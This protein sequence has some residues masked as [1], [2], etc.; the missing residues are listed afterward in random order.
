MNGKPEV[1]R[2][3]RISHPARSRCLPGCHIV[4]LPE[5]SMGA[6]ARF[7]SVA[8]VHKHS[9]RPSVLNSLAIYRID[10]HHHGK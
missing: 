2:R 8:F 4:R 1:N 3:R 6:A 10:E 5:R 7:G 9:A